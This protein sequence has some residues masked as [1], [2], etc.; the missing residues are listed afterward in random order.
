MFKN[1][2]N[3][4][5][6]ML[7]AVNIALSTQ[8]QFK[9]YDFYLKRNPTNAQNVDTS[10]PMSLADEFKAIKLAIKLYIYY[11]NLLEESVFMNQV[12]REKAQ[13]GFALVKS[14]LEN[15]MTKHK[16]NKFL[17]SQVV[18]EY[19]KALSQNKAIANTNDESL[20]KPF[21]WG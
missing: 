18:Q 8:I 4:F 6:L 17:L 21:M 7:L 10:S 19:N 2:N 15:F 1:L 16:N 3:V 12:Q 14:K 20:R 5:L 9:P 11:H 13:N